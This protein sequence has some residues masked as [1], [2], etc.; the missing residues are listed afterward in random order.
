MIQIGG[1]RVVAW[2]MD[3]RIIDVVIKNFRP[4]DPFAAPVWFKGRRLYF[5]PVSS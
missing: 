1:E 5:L 4:V 3:L 2:E